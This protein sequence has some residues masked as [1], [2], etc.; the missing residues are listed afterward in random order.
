MNLATWIAHDTY[1]NWFRP[2]WFLI[3]CGF[4]ITI[5]LSWVN[6]CKRD[7]PTQGFYW[8]IFVIT[9]IA[10]LGASFF[11]KYDVKNPIFFF[12]LFAFWEPG[13]SIHGGLIFGLITCWI[14]FGFES[15]KHNISLWVYA[16]LIVSNILLAQA[17]GRWGNFFNH[18]L[19]GAPIAREQL[20][21]LP[22]FIRDNLFKWYV[23]T[24]VP[25]NF[26]PT[27][28][29]G[30]N[31]NPANP[32]DFNNVQYF[33]PIFLY[34]SLANILLWFLIVIA[35][36]LI[37]RYSYYWRFKK[38][39]PDFMQLSWK[40]VWAKWYY[41]IKPDP[42]LVNNLAQ[43]VN[44][45]K[46]YFKN[47]HKMTKKQVIKA[48][49]EYYGS[50]LKQIFTADV[51]EL[52]KIENPHRLKILRCGIKTGMYIAGYN[53]IRIILETQRDDH[54]LF[55]KN[56]RTLDYVILSLM[57]VIGII[58]ILFAQWIAVIKWRKGGWLYEK[59]Y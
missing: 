44:L 12:T 59:Q 37:L 8:G 13:M 17:I 21:W 46:V 19:L 6:F 1:G 3:F 27:E 29:I 16:D 51:R 35:L 25:N 57:I 55:L 10:L 11:G 40:G 42:M 36:P 32:T 9:P 41:D 28:A 48:H 38:E 54:D 47:K 43:Q 31:G 58:L 23:P 49:W 22:S 45:K 33:Q 50:R 2:Y 39:E 34:E 5:I 14:W 18:E 30:I 56:M 52:E 26:H 7:I 24:P 4:A 53:L 20:M 15:R